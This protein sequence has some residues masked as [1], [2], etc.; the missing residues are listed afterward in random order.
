MAIKLNDHYLASFIRPHEYERIADEVRTADAML[1]NKTGAGND[2]LGW[3]NLPE[4]YDKEEFARIKAAAKKIQKTADVLV[5]IGI[6]G[7][8]LGARAVIEYLKSPNSTF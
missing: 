5:V 1:R 3:V 8:Y 2:F 6:G 4:N 7:S